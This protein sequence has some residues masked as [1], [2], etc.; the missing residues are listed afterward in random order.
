MAAAVV[1]EIESDPRVKELLAALL[2]DGVAATHHLQRTAVALMKKIVRLWRLHTRRQRGVQ[3]LRR[4]V[5]SRLSRRLLSSC[6]GAW[7][8]F[9]RRQSVGHLLLTRRNQ[10]L[11]TRAWAQWLHALRSVA[12]SQSCIRHVEKCRLR[13][14][15]RRLRAWR[16]LVGLEARRATKLRLCV[17]LFQMIRIF[18]AWQTL[19]R[20]S[21][22]QER[23]LC[24]DW[25]AHRLAAVV[26]AWRDVSC[27]H[28]GTSQVLRRSAEKLYCL[29]LFRRMFGCWRSLF[30]FRMHM[31]SCG[32]M[33]RGW[34]RLR[35]AAFA[36]RLQRTAFNKLLADAESIGT[37]RALLHWRSWARCAGML[38][39]ASEATSAA[40]IRRVQQAT[41]STWSSSAARCAGETRRLSRRVAATTSRRMLKVSLLCWKALVQLRFR[42]ERCLRVNRRDV[43]PP[44]VDDSFVSTRESA[45]HSR[46]SDMLQSSIASKTSHRHSVRNR[47]IS[48]T[49]WTMYLIGF[50]I[51]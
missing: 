22:A 13:R 32:V 5:S 39:L 3:S 11:R 1:S 35:R 25:Y 51:I 42:G 7:V 49:T 43:A 2:G 37:K 12:R 31:V 9:A 33:R 24:S 48:I 46:C 10:R 29:S 36:C 26:R 15:F 47:R 4:R 19:A 40:T 28:L 20:A 14:A 23:K 21:A 44:A 16:L 6:Y 8:Q 27:A 17:D 38:R 41:W 30:L 50:M 34:E 45:A 18:R